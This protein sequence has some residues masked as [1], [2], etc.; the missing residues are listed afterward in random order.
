M[1]SWNGGITQRQLRWLRQELAAAEA[2]GERVLVASHHQL[3]QGGARATHMAWNWRKVQEVG[4]AVGMPGCT[5]LVAAGGW[6]RE[7]AQGQHELQLTRQRKHAALPA[8][9]AVLAS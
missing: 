2:A 9:N 6:Y 3:G 5:L 1:S 8:I 7:V 4:G